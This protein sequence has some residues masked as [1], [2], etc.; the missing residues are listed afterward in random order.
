MR[1]IGLE[2]ELENPLYSLDLSHIDAVCFLGS[3]T[4]CYPSLSILGAHPLLYASLIC[5]LKLCTKLQSC[6]FSLLFGP[7]PS[8]LL[9]LLDLGPLLVQVDSLS[10]F[11]NALCVVLG[12][13]LSAEPTDHFVFLLMLT[14]AEKMTHYTLFLR[15]SNQDSSWCIIQ[16]CLRELN[17]CG[18]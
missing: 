17:G 11:Q 6:Q 4:T 15:F 18:G 14:Q 16:I 3:T 2:A 9:Y 12:Q 10:L 1:K 13:I 5:H 8:L 7:C